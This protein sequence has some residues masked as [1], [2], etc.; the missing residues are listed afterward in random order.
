MNYSFDFVYRENRDFTFVEEQF[1][2]IVQPVYGDQ[3]YALRKIGE[4]V[5]RTCRV[6]FENNKPVGLIVTKKALSNEFSHLN[7][8]NAL[9]LKTLL[10]AD[11]EQNAGK[12]INSKLLQEAEEVAKFKEASGI[13]VTVS[14]KQPGSLAFFKN[15]G[16]LAVCQAF[17]LRPSYAWYGGGFA[18]QIF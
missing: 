7:I 3:S 16:Y 18:P 10:V 12:G 9:E 15:N 2:R 8:K 5:D 4:G 14:E 17:V 11:P 6:L 13:F 1:K